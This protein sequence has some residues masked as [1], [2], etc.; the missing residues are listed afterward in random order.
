MTTEAGCRDGVEHHSANGLRAL[1]R[2]VSLRLLA[3]WALSGCTPAYLDVKVRPAT[4]I[5][6]VAERLQA[7]GISVDHAS[8]QPGR[9]RTPIVCF[10]APD[11]FGFDWDRGFG[12]IGP[13]PLSF[14]VIGEEAKQT[15]AQARCPYQFRVNVIADPVQAGSRLRVE[16][17]WWRLKRLGCHPHGPRLMGEVNCRYT[18]TGT[19]APQDVKPFIYGILRGI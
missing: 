9:L 3:A 6:T 10:M 13:G 14:N 4:A 2:S 8:R 15:E 19:S 11:R 16:A 5:D 7:R 12:P 1:S 17:D 18:Y